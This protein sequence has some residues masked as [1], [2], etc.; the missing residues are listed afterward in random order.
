M[1]CRISFVSGVSSLV[2]FFGIITVCFLWSLHLNPII[3]AVYGSAYR[4]EGP[5]SL[6]V[7]VGYACIVLSSF[8][9]QPVVSS[10]PFPVTT[11]TQ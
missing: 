3:D 7:Y 11:G 10:M 2:F 6:V 4:V 9:K 5:P 1:R 8:H